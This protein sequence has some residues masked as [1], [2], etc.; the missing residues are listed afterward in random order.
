LTHD[1]E[2]LHLCDPMHVDKNVTMTL[3]KT[4]SNTK[5]TRFDLAML[6]NAMKKIN[7]MDGLRTIKFGFDKNGNKV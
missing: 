5:D 1:L 4:L 7:I 2:L 3:F 6:R